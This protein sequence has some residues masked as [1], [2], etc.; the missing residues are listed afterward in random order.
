MFIS[1]LDLEQ[2]DLHTL[3]PLIPDSIYRAAVVYSHS[4]RETREERYWDKVEV[5]RR[6][7]EGFGRWGRVG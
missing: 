2:I 5:L 6:S 3:A 1:K 4:A 7:L